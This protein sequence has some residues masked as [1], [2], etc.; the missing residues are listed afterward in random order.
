[1]EMDEGCTDEDV[2]KVF[3]NVNFSG[4]PMSKEHIKFVQG[5]Y[6]NFNNK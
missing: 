2:L 5:I 6:N 4:K 3:L 1:M